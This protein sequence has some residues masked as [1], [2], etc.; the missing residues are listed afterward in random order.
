MA[1]EQLRQD[2]LSAE[3]GEIVFLLTGQASSA[4]AR[5]T[6]IANAPSSFMGLPL[7]SNSSG[8]QEQDETGSYLGTAVYGTSG[9]GQSG[10]QVGDTR[11]LMNSVGGSVHITQSLSTP[12]SH[13]IGGGVNIPDFKGAIGVQMPDHSVAGTDILAGAFDFT[14]VKIVDA[15]TLTTSYIA[16]ILAL[17]TPNPHTNQAMFTHTDSDGRTVTLA[18]GEGLFVGFSNSPRDNGEDELR[19]E[20][21]GSANLTGITIGDMTGIAKDGWEHLWVHYLADE[22]A[23]AHKLLQRPFYA[24]VEQVYEAGDWSD[25][26]L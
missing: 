10:L 23:S 22:D 1:I 18:I 16:D 24:Y 25:L 13:G 7:R 4:A 2:R 12:H 5:T 19:F 17:N 26:G 20:F 3:S 15:S 14:I 8:V 9:G 11:I 21:K 6:L